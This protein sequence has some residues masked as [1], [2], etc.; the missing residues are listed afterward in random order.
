[1]GNDVLEE[2]SVRVFGAFG[3]DED[4]L[5]LEDEEEL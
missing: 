1:M 4:V 2:G 5:F 3:G